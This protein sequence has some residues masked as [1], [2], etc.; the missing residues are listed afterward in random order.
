MSFQDPLAFLLLS[1]IPVVYFFR[2]RRKKKTR[3]GVPFPA[4]SLLSDVP[5]SLRQK[6][7]ILKPILLIAA[8]VSLVIAIARPRYG[9]EEV[10]DV[11]R[12]IAIEMVLDRSGSMGAQV[13]YGGRDVSRL[14]AVKSL[15][16]SFVL[17]NGDELK[18]RPDDLVGMVTFARYAE[19]VYPLSLSH[20]TINTFLKNVSVVTDKNL[21][22]TA[23][24]DAIALGAARLK[25]AEIGLETDKKNG[26]TI[27]SKI[28]ILL[29][30]GQNNWGERS[31]LKAAELAAQWGIKIYAIGIGGKDSWVTVD[32]PFGKKRISAP[33]TLDVDT[34]TEIAAKTGGRYFT[35][36]T[37]KDITSVYSTINKLEKTEIESVKYMDYREAFLPFALLSLFFITV[38]IVLT[39]TLLRRIP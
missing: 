29:T 18:G 38:F 12:G 25:T 8:M 19:T 17:G 7:S 5:S 4:V 14:E 9:M 16:T 35:A 37:V 6:L 22:G 30:D 2:L 36:D 13:R 39:T 32:T 27:K 31:P 26:Y 10:R 23:I 3:N 21:D 28:I 20:T 1:T 11:S 34:L 15:F 24:G 33:S